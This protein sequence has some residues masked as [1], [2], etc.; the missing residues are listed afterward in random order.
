MRVYIVLLALTVFAVAV[1]AEKNKTDDVGKSIKNWIEFV[2]RF[3][4]EDP[5]G[6]QIAQLAK[7]WNETAPEARCKV[8]TLLAENRR[9]L[10]N[11]TA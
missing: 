11:K 8:R 2:H 10:K 1:S 9:G 7:D 6:K 3:F 5:I 4:Y